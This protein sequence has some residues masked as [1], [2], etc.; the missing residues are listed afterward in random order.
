MRAQHDCRGCIEEVLVRH[1]H[2]SLR[3]KTRHANLQPSS[4]LKAT[5][6]SLTLSALLA[7]A[8]PLR[9]R[10]ESWRQTLPILSKPASELDAEEFEHGAG[11]RLSHLALEILIFRALLRPLFYQAAQQQPPS[12]NPREP[13]AAIFENGYMCAKV[14]SDIVSSLQA[15]HFASFWPPC[16]FLHHLVHI[17]RVHSCEHSA[18]TTG[19]FGEH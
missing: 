6:E 7:R 5:S 19:L 10:I 2:R 16:E 12:D 18:F 8:Q 9:A 11:L 15:R 14:A 3:E 4:T 1:H 13:V 17:A